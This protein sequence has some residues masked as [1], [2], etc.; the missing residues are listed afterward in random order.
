VWTQDLILSRQVPYHL[1]HA[2]SPFCFNYFSNRVSLFCQGLTLNHDSSTYASY[3][4]EIIDMYHYT[5]LVVDIGS[6]TNFFGHA[7]L[8]LHFSQTPPPE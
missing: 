7:G 3:I 4:A 8:K 6:L 1:N 2:P 5:C